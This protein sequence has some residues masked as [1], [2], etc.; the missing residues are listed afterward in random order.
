MATTTPAS[1]LTLSRTFTPMRPSLAPHWDPA[2][3]A[4][5]ERALENAA[6]NE[7]VALDFDNTC[8]QGDTGELFHLY[9]SETLRWDLD[10]FADRLDDADGRADFC[11]K[12]ARWRA[13]GEGRSALF[14]ALMEAFP[15]RIERE[16]AQ[17]TYAWATSLHAGLREDEHRTLSRAMLMREG[18]RDR[19]RLIL[20]RETDEHPPLII[21]RGLRT[22]P[23]L[24]ALVEVAAD[25]SI[26]TWVVSATNR[27]TVEVAA[28]DLAIPRDRVIGNRTRV[29]EGRI[30]CEPDGPAT[31]HQGKVDALRALGIG[32]ALA[33]GDSWSDVPMMEYARQ[34]L[35][36]DRGDGAL[37]QLAEERG[38]IIVEAG[39]LASVPWGTF[40]SQE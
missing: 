30:T 18:T 36:I 6:A 37:R 19:E 17:K 29:D 1:P 32:V 24:R 22:R 40:S 10:N 27:W 25:A 15:R 5:L 14:R 38:W 7:V 13:T 23:A 12:L 11:E 28:E 16:G 20:S 35:L 21:R 33:G 8:V 4:A 31:W 9:L 34:G 26:P 2:A 39:A 3:H